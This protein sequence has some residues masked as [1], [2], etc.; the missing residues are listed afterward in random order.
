MCIRDSAGTEHLTTPPDS[1]HSLTHFYNWSFS[2]VRTTY[3]M[4][5]DGDMVLTREGIGYLA[6]LSWQLEDS[7]AVVDHG[8]H[9]CVLP[10]Q[11]G[12]RQL[13]ARD[14]PV[15]DDAHPG[16]DQDD[17]LA[18]LVQERADGLGEAGQL[19]RHPRGPTTA[20]GARAAARPAAASWSRRG[21]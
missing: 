18:T 8:E 13:D 5:W 12:C 20:G 19:F 6:D 2:Q 11:L 3:S 15:P 17:L 1:V 4:K 21:R 16:R 7:G 10:A 9:P 14:V